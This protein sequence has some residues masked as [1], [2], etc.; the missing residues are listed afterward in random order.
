MPLRLLALFLGLFFLGMG[1]NKLAWIADPDLLTQRFVRWLPTAAPYAQWY[2]QHIAIPGA[3]FF[4]RLVP[5]GELVA[6]VALVLGFRTNVIAAI[7]LI[8]VLNFHLATS[9]FSSWEFLRD[10]TGPPVIGALLALAVGGRGLPWS[11]GG[12]KKP[13]ARGRKTIAAA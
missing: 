10:G 8:M 9:A 7:A 2:L 6:G 11:V 5:I 12:V 3:P 4:A 13:R 1:S